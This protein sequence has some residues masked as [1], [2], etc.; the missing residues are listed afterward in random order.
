MCTYIPGVYTYQ[1]SC[2][3]PASPQYLDAHAHSTT[4]AR[5]GS[6]G[7]L[8]AWTLI[9]S[10]IGTDPSE[11]DLTRCYCSTVRGTYANSATPSSKLLSLTSKL[12]FS[13][14]CQNVTTEMQRCTHQLVA[15]EAECFGLKG[16]T[17][18]MKQIIARVWK[19]WTHAI[20][21]TTLRTGG[22]GM[23]GCDPKSPLTWPL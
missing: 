12:L 7:G 14:T 8:C 17:S 4:C 18:V 19:I 3:C 22:S 5:W 6:C 11:C 16:V 1:Q 15:L 23:T 13:S 21:S 20:C 10:K 9:P 2:W